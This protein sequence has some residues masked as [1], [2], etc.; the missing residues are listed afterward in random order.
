M[1]SGRRGVGE[2]VQLSPL[3]CP[4]PNTTTPAQTWPDCDRKQS[5]NQLA[6]PSVI[7]W[8]NTSGED[9]SRRMT[10]TFIQSCP[11]TPPHSHHFGLLETV[12]PA[13]IKDTVAL[14]SIPIC[15][16]LPQRESQ[17]NSNLVYEGGKSSGL[18]VS[19]F[20]FLSTTCSHPANKSSPCA[21]HFS[22]FVHRRGR[23]RGINLSLSHQTQSPNFTSPTI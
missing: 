21:E 6:Y 9:N 5:L 17:S 10:F 8:F 20:D 22:L 19:H 2:V 1:E 11:P 13:V 16:Y 12:W 7:M 3:H 14:S 18:A 4:P 23:P 15:A